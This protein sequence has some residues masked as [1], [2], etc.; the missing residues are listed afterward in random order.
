M[1]R[2]ILIVR[3]SAIGDVVMASGL[4]PAL[5]A[6]YPDAY[7]AWLAEPAV[8]EL[9]ADNPRLDEVIVW[10]RGEWRRLWRERRYRALWQAISASP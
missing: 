4:L 10:P 3:L 2:R 5:R 6:R 8:R 7:I 9:L 1:S